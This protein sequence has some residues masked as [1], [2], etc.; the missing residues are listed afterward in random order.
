M[1]TRLLQAKQVAEMLATTEGRVYEL[2][3]LKL[4]PVCRLG[5]QVRFDEATLVEWIRKG[6]QS[7]PGGWKQ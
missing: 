5:R 3:R 7:L 4:I 1:Q 2:A 6:G